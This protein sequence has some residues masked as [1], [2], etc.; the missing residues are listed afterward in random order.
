M[1]NIT[2]FSNTAFVE[3]HGTGTSVGDP[4][5]AKAIAAVFGGDA[6][7]FI[8]SVKPNLGHSEGASGIT[9]L[10]KCV[11]SLENQTIPPNIKFSTPNP[12]IPFQESNLT[13]PVEPTTWPESRHERISINSFGIGGTNAHVIL[14]SARSFN[15][16]N[17][18]NTTNSAAIPAAARNPHTYE[19]RPQLLLLS[20]TS[21]SSLQKTNESFKDLISSKCNGPE[22]SDYLQNLAYTLANRRELFS[23]R[24]FIV[25]SSDGPGVVSSGRKAASPRPNLVMVFTGQ[26]AQWPRMDRELL[27]RSDL[28]FQSSIRSLDQHLREAQ[29]P[30]T[31]Q[32]TLEE[33]LLKPTKKS[34]VQT[35]ELSQPL[36]TAVQIALVDLFAAVGIEPHAVVGHSSGEIAAAYA[37]GALSAKEAIIAAWQ[38]GLA[39]KKQTKPGAM[40]AVGLSWDDIRGFL[41][42]KVVVACENSPKSVTLSGDAIEVE[43]TISQIKKAYPNALA[44]LLKVDKAYYSYLMREIGN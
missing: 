36:C 35:A 7:V 37:A 38:R 5:E 31:P 4:L 25:A 24:S 12:K 42:P 15:V 34:S 11:L 23:H 39:V 44:R 26:G 2:D 41:S 6:G 3:C 19:A 16:A 8:G 43:E 30:A 29:A 17:G 33:E 18:H 27:L 28:C 40:A 32:W 14:D 20:A 13:V 21:A 9:S 10:I 22:S 1:A